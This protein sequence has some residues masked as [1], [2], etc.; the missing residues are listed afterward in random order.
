MYVSLN[1]LAEL[2][3]CICISEALSHT[4]STMETTFVA[5][6]TNYPIISI[7]TNI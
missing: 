1:D 6:V 3:L 2:D 4:H 5:V 7:D